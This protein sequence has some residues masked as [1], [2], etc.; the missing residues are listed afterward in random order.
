MFDFDSWQEIRESLSRHKLRTA[1]TAFGVFWGIF[2]LVNLLGV[3]AG[4]KNGA[5]A[6]IGQFNNAVF[7]WSGGPT[8][9]PYKGLAKGRRPSLNDGDIEA[10]RARI[11]ELDVIAPGN[12]MG[13]QFT[14]YENKSDSFNITGIVPV[15]LAAKGYTLVKGRFLN[16]L[17]QNQE[18]KTVVIGE[19]VSEILFGNE[20]EPIGKQINIL[21][22][23]FLV[24][25]I[26]RPSA[27]NNW[28]Q[29]DLTK[30]F[31]PH[32][33]MRKTFNQKDRIHRL[34]ITPKA[35][36]SSVDIERKV[37]S[38]LQERHKVHPKDRGV[39]GSYNVQKNYNSI[40]SLFGGIAA[41]SWVVAIGTIIAGV[42]GVG[43]IMLIT[44]K[45]RTREI[46]IRK[47][48]GATP[49]DIVATIVKESLVLTCV[50]GYSGLVCGVLTVEG[51]NLIAANADGGI[52]T[53]LNPQVS[54]STA[55][56][57]IAI[58]I[59]AGACAAYLPAR[60][61]ASIDPVLALQDE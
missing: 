47:A 9:I 11:P 49:A 31:L 7:V 41:F 38:L 54:F 43:N 13:D 6:N 5:E 16:E 23:P 61:A 50:A 14:V 21:G 56:W 27:L 22:V 12:G 40:Q 36:I 48:I 34:M 51:I 39:I 52:G 4:L 46:G 19:R 44:V 10:L 55:M 35:G 59:L 32:S 42:V 29:R 60:R 8:S 33:T 1:L 25:G 26:I 57:A 3:G 2:M 53:F 17:D 15:E 24:V 37:V 45:E 18:R 58:L 30:I 28:A 20:I